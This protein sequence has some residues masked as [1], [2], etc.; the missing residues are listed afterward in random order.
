MRRHPDITRGCGLAECQPRR[1]SKVTLAG[2]ATGL[3]Q[4]P[5]FSPTQA[6]T[7]FMIC[8]WF[9]SR[10]YGLH[11]PKCGVWVRDS[12]IALC[13]SG[14]VGAAVIGTPSVIRP[15]ARVP[16]FRERPA[17]CMSRQQKEPGHVQPWQRAKI[18][19]GKVVWTLGERGA[20]YREGAPSRGHASL[21]PSPVSFAA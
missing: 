2:S 4:M 11:T 21:E 1:N 3:L 5:R 20:S 12:H 16:A 19:A 15:L 14:S 17:G 6:P 13:E 18:R 10:D 9:S 8:S 7:L